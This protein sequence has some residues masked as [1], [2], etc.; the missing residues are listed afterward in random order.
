[1]NKRAH[2][3]N[4]VIPAKSGIS[5]ASRPVPQDAIDPS[6]RWGDDYFIGENS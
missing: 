3:L 1:M 2:C 5:L 6:L 4:A